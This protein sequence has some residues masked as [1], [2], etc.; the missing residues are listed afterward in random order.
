MRIIIDLDQVRTKR[1]K[2]V[3]FRTKFYRKGGEP[4]YVQ[5]CGV[6]IYELLKQGLSASIENAVIEHEGEV[7]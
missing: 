4:L 1:G 6:E 3:R 7:R 5:N 2:M